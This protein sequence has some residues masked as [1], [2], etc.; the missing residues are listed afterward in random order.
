IGNKLA[1]FI[2]N[3]DIEGILVNFSILARNLI[4]GLFGFLK[5]FIINT[6]WI[7]LGEQIFNGITGMIE[8]I[9][10]ENLIENAFELLGAAVGG[11]SA[12]ISSLLMKIWEKLKEAWN[13][14]K[15]YFNK[16]IEECGGNVIGGVFKGILDAFKNIGNW[17]KEHIFKPFIDGFKKAFGIHSPSK[18]MAEMGGYIIAG[19]FNSISDGITKIREIFEKML[20]TIKT[21]FSDIGKWF[22]DKFSS[23]W[24]GIKSVWN[25][26]NGYFSGIWDGITF[27]FSVVGNWFGEKFQSAWNNIKNIFSEVK[28]FFEGVW[29]GITNVFSH[30]TNWFRDTFSDAW[31]AVKNVFSKGGEIFTGITD[32]IYN[33]FKTVVNG[34]IDGM[35]WVIE[36]PFNTINWALDG[37]RGIEIL[38]WYPFEWLPS[39]TIPEIPK[40]ANGGL[41]TAPTLAMVGDNRNAKSD[42]EV[43]APLSKL[44]GMIGD[45]SEITE[46]LK[47]II[48]L[49]KNGM[50]I[51]II[52]YMFRNSR[53][54]SREVIRAVAE[55]NTR[56]GGK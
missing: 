1:E 40:L 27:T 44:E 54:F 41:A 29:N 18:E 42:P 37:I 11:I 15:E 32:G 12:L 17:I 22:K 35:N 50:N 55:D 45:N 4:K 6:D 23:A 26:V 53:E 36:Q 31:Q 39:I 9:D 49:L 24:N 19:L 46:M 21:V 25:A 7:S 28:G 5:N 52:N 2:N 51:E 30:V 38:D 33:T 34:L 43:I 14:V 13:S 56:R 47:I 20:E 16:K 10:W 48:E 8:N 3:I